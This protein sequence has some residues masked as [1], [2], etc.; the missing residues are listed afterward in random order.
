MNK[1][2]LVDDEPNV[3]NALRREL[4]E[5]FEI[6][7]FSNPV[8]ALERCRNTQF[9]LVVADYKM[10]ELNGL[11]F[12]KQFGPLQPDAARLVLSGEADIDALIRTIN[13][14][15]I[16]RFLA[17]PWESAELLSSIRQALAYR[18]TI[19]ES[20]RQAELQRNDVAPS[21]RNDAPY[22]IVLV[23]NDER[24]LAL[25]SRG[26]TDESG[27]ESLYGAMQQEIGH[28]S[29]KKFKCVVDTFR[30][31]A[32]ALDHAE[33]NRCDLVIAAQSLPDMGGIQLLG[34]L[35]QT[36][37]DVARILLSDDPDKAMLS[38]AI[39]TAEVQSLLQLHWS[40]HELRADVRR[41]AWNLFQLKSAAI[42][43]LA[44]RELRL[45]NSRTTA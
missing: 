20:R 22:R 16:Y 42:Q 41:Q 19:L 11:E 2:L 4:K 23:E 35:K 13:E 10:P 18:D 21:P 12:L 7:T 25:M 1:I 40:S 30:T 33:K 26:L 28:G 43:A 45:Q 6:E 27:R 3:L 31:A 37:A 38:Q 5:Y 29:T 8:E 14:T 24:L 17:K 44:S 15:H 9:D 36:H 32:A 39:N 34:Q